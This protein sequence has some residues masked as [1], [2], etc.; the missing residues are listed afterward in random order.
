MVKKFLS[1]FAIASMMLAT[2][3]AN[4]EFDSIQ[5][6]NEAT[7]SFTAQL[8]DGLQTKSRAVY[9][10]GTTATKLQ[11]A[12]YEVNG[13]DWSHV[14]LD[15]T[16]T[17]TNLKTTI[18]LQLVN[19]KTY[20]VVFWADAYANADNAP[21]TFSATENDVKVTADYNG[22]TS[23]NESLDA[24]FAVETITVTGAASKDVELKRP[25]AQL[26]IGTADLE[27]AQKAGINVAGA[28]IT[29]DTYTSFDFK[30][31]DVAGDAKRVT[32]GK[33][34]LPTEETFPVTGYKYLTM[35]YLLMP[36]DKQTVDVT[37][38]YGGKESPIYKNVP[39]Q[40]NYRTNIYG[41]L[42]TS[43]N[44][45]NVEIKP[46]FDGDY[47][48]SVW[49][50]T[51]SDKFTKDEN[52]YYRIKS[53]ADF[54]L[55][56]EKTQNDNSPYGGKTF[57]L[58]TDISF[59]GKTITGV[60]SDQCNVSFTFD[61]N[62]HTISDFVINNNRE[63]YAGLF[64]QV[65][66]GGY[67]KKLT[68]KNA[69]VIGQRMVGAIASNVESGCVI[70]NCHVENC[71][72][73]SN[74]K[75]AGA[76]VGYALG[77]VKDCSAK[78]VN[79]YCADADKNES[80]EIVGYV[81][82]GS[83]ITDNSHENVTVVCGTKSSA[84][85]SMSELQAALTNGGNV[86]LLN[87]IDVNNNYA[88]TPYVDNKNLCLDGN[89]CT[90]SKL[91]KPLLNCYGGNIT[92]KNLTVKDSNVAA[93][94]TDETGDLGAGIIL[95][96]AQWCNLYMENCH[97]QNSSLTASDTR[98]GAMV[99]Y[100][101]GGGEIKNCSVDN[102]V[103]ESDD[104][105]AG[106]AAHRQSQDGYE[107]IAKISN[108][109]VKNSKISSTKKGTFRTGAILGTNA[110]GTTVITNCTV[111]DNTTVSQSNATNEACSKLLGRVAGGEVNVDGTSYTPAN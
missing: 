87:D 33:G 10:D 96:Q 69:T 56:M 75:K 92:I 91:N 73:V 28:G 93:N 100:W 34:S 36:K 77:T 104:T 7:V 60:G 80:G 17:F 25:F 53:A 61:G 110:A 107:A 4:D 62:N 35:N 68:V 76:V 98:A 101:I 3:C 103:V 26:N 38:D 99:G 37:L 2:S 41:K 58:D 18:N 20:N 6:G 44:D 97:I 5:T 67:I 46:G 90:I 83:T 42:L 88:N 48:E 24:F 40:R 8:P 1:V 89:G 39:L 86:I 54:A 81:N 65:S 63:W 109:T 72:V 47:N 108:C 64:N 30:T 94:G 79:V 84:V 52:G 105:A 9:G 31:K 16:A 49:D 95:E 22:I 21:Y 111:S 43:Q 74:L 27:E 50:G 13:T 106:I 70:E 32:F 14:N 55:L 29:V 66:H 59:G 23:N 82:E 12:V 71:I 78:N 51:V 45:F 19:G 11:Y 15:G 85:S 57:V 102:C